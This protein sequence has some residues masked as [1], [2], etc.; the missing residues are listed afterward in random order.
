M[1]ISTTSTAVSGS[2][3]STV[4]GSPISLFWLCSANTVGTTAAQSAPRMSFVVVLPV[5]PTTA[6]TRASERERTRDASVASAAC[7][8]SGTSVTAPR[9]RAS[10][11]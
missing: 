10:S 8:S 1:P 6:T 2:S 4:S 11:T 9:A 7:W 5:E 3:R